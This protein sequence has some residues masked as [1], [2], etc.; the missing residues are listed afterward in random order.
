MSTIQFTPAYG[1]ALMCET[2]EQE[3][4]RLKM[5]LGDAERKLQR[6]QNVIASIRVVKP[7][8]L[9]VE[10]VLDLIEQMLREAV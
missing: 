5:R 2:L 7:R 6:L 8:V 10:G 4:E 9:P 1:L 3:N